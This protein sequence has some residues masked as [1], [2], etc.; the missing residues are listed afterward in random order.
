MI[1]ED[2]GGLG[3]FEG[4][5]NKV[6]WGKLDGGMWESPLPHGLH[7]QK[8]EIK[9]ARHACVCVFVYNAEEIGQAGRHTVVL[10]DEQQPLSAA[11]GN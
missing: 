3:H 5:I 9:L 6:S 10:A 11:S 8:V 7:C 2:S 4:T 1:L